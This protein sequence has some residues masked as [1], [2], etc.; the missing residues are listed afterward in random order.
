VI[1]ATG[2]HIGQ[3]FHVFEPTKRDLEKALDSLQDAGHIQPAAI[4]DG[5]AGWV[6]TRTLTPAD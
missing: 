2:K 3:V 6:S 1:T 4:K 5:A